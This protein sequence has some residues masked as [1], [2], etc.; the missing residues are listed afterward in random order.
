[1]D[2]GR[3]TSVKSAALQESREEVFLRTYLKH[4][5]TVSPSQ[6]RLKFEKDESYS[7]FP[8][9]QPGTRQRMAGT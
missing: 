2:Q 3:L 8:S 4:S 6:G 9:S 1:M 7:G 5:L